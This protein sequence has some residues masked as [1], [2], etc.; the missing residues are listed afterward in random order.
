MNAWTCHGTSQR[1]MVEKLASAGIIQSPPVKDAMR[2][3][4]RGNY[5][6]D[7]SSAYIDSPQPIGH[8]QTMSAPHMH[9]HALEALMPT[10]IKRSREFPNEK[11]NILDVGCGSGFLTACLGRLVDRG[12]NG[13]IKPLVKGRVYGIDAFPELLDFATSNMSKSDSD[14]FES[15]TV[16]LKV[17]DGWQGFPDIAPFD[18]IH[19][20]AAANTF[21]P[22]LMMQLKVG[23][24]MIIPVG[25]D[26]G[27]QELYKVRRLRDAKAYDLKDFNVKEILRVRY[28]PL[29]HPHFTGGQNE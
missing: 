29:F 18:A 4:D 21:P 8:G 6:G 25:P 7:R 2:I 5:A 17:K 19:V 14:L 13:P 9:A 27:V 3:V 12:P 22:A 11:L 23:G 15:G 16:D 10:L 1:E 28:V 20:G 24:V 26:G